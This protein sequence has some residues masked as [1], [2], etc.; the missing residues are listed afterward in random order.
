MITSVFPVQLL[1]LYNLFSFIKV[2][3][4]MSTE[5]GYNATSEYVQLSFIVSCCFISIK[6][7]SSS[8]QNCKLELRLPK[9]HLCF[10]MSYVW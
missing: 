5:E 7:R 8:L 6:Y 2:N 4:N 10:R 9:I 3:N 1:S